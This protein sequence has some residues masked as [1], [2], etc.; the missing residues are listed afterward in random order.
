M[1][2]RRKARNIAKTHL[3]IF[4]DL[5]AKPPQAFWNKEIQKGQLSAPAM[6]GQEDMGM[7]SA[8]LHFPLG[9]P[10]CLCPSTE[11]DA[12]KDGRL[13]KANWK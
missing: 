5:E 7:K 11:G 8:C 13:Q 6:P 2:A 9:Q 4:N 3:Q 12:S 10:F 1:A